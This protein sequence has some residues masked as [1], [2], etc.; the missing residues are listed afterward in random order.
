M[1]TLN[2]KTKRHVTVIVSYFFDTCY[3]LQDREKPIFIKDKSKGKADSSSA[4]TIVK[5]CLFWLKNIGFYALSTIQLL[6]PRDSSLETYLLVL[7]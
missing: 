6:F 1:P 7:F 2:M 4:L 3:H 5:N